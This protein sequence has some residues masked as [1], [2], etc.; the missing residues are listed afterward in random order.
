MSIPRPG[1]VLALGGLLA[2]AVARDA[3]GLV[4]T[5]VH[6]HAPGPQDE[7]RREEFVEIYNED[8]D[9]LDLSGYRFVEG[10]VYEFPARTFLQ[11]RSYLVI[12]AD[13]ARLRARHGITNAIGDWASSTSLDNGGESIALANPGGAVE[14][15][16]EYNDRGRW[17]AGADG[18]GLTLSLRD[19][20]ADPSRPES[21][22]ASAVA[23]GTPG[24]ANF[25]GGAP[26]PPTLVMNEA[27]IRTAGPRWVEIR[28]LRNATVN[29]S[30]HY[31]T[32]DPA[33][34]E[35]A[36][37]PA[38]SSIPPLGRI[39]FEDEPL[40]LDFSLDGPPVRDMVFVGLVDPAGRIV[41]AFSFRPTIDGASEARIPDGTGDMEPAA[42]PTPGAP[43]TVSVPT[44]IVINEI[45]YHPIDEDGS[46]EFIELWNRGGAEVDISGWSFTNGIT[47]TFP[48]TTRLAPGAFL[49]LARDPDRIRG[50]YGL[51]ASTVVGPLDAASLDAFGTLAD[52]GE[53]L[54]LV[55]ARGNTVDSVEYADG[56]E[57]P[58]WPDGGGSTLELIDA[59]QDNDTPQAWD[60]SDDSDKARS[61]R[62]EYTAKHNGGSA[63]ESEIHAML[64][65]KG[66]ALVDDL[67]I[68]GEAT[69]DVVQDEV[70]AKPGDT[71]LIH[72]GTAPPSSP[73]NAW[74]DPDFDASSWLQGTLPIGYGESNLGTTLDDMRFSYL[75]VCLRREFQVADPSIPDRLILEVDYDDGFIAYLNGGEVAR[76]N[77]PGSPPAHDAAAAESREAGTPQRIDITGRKSLLRSGKNVLALQLHNNIINSP[78]VFLTA[79]LYSGRNVSV[80]AGWNMVLNGSFEDP[81]DEEWLIKGTHARSGRTA[82]G[83]LQGSASLKLLAS[84][85]G[86]EKINHIERDIPK[87]LSV[88][89]E[90]RVS[91]EAKWV[92]GARSLLTCGHN[93][94]LARSHHLEVPENVGTPGAPNS[95][96]LRLLELSGA[97]N[98]GPVIDRV[99]T[100][101]AAPPPGQPVTL[102]ARIRD[103]DGVGSAVVRWALDSPLAAFSEIP[104]TGPDAEGFWSAEIPG[105]ALNTR[106]V[107][108]VAALDAGARPGRHPADI[109]RRTH[110]LLLDPANPSPVDLSWGIY[111]HIS[112]QATPHNPYHFWMHRPHEEYLSSRGVHS[113]EYLEGAFLFGSSTLYQGA[114]IRFQ[115]S[116][117][118]RAGWGGSFRIRFPSDRPLH[119]RSAR[120]N[121]DQDGPNARDRISHY[122]V[123]NNTGAIR[124]P[125]SNHSFARL[126]VNARAI[127]TRVRIDPPG[128]EYLSKWFPDDTDGELFEIDERY[129][130][131]DAGMA[132]TRRNAYWLHPP[133]P[134]EGSGE[135]PE[136]YR[137][138]FTLRADEDEDDFSNLIATARVLTPSLT[139]AAQFD[140]AIWSHLD[141]EEFVRVLTIRQ[142]T[143]DW[144]TWAGIFGRSAYIY[145]A[146]SDG[147]W[148]LFPWDSDKAYGVDSRS[149]ETQPLPATP[150]ETF[151]NP[152]PEVERLINRPA[153][154]RIYYAVLRQMVDG[155]FT[156][157]Y[158]APY[159]DLLEAAGASRESLAVGRVGGFIDLRGKLIRG[160]IGPHMYP[161]RRLSIATNGG[162]P[163]S[164]DSPA[165]TLTGTL[166]GGITTLAI[167]VNGVAA[168]EG[169]A[170]PSS[171]DFF[172]WSAAAIPLEPGLNDIEVLG[173]SPEGDLVDA[174]TI[175]V[176]RG[177]D[178]EVFL[179]G[180][181]D[182]DAVLS[183][184]DAV[185]ILSHL[186]QGGPMTCLD[187][188][189]VD[190]SGQLDITDPIRLLNYLFLGGSPPPPPFMS[191]GADP[192]PDGL[193]CRSGS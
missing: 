121:L 93:F 177:S 22:A 141:V 34:L 164:T 73:A 85:A 138:H 49:V 81:L 1:P 102:R 53:R 10:L 80:P 130:F 179:R 60:A 128:S 97:V 175:T 92:V 5:E 176:T 46:R 155:H 90:Y 166:P 12:C 178:A 181:T 172:G 152:F 98:L 101:P 184:T 120:F 147:L 110:P 35:K 192:T 153:V 66:I 137:F 13:A 28:N 159:L 86:D 125:F 119:G 87:G 108:E 132:L 148:R 139:P 99:V 27:L 189:D 142:N 193:D 109:T 57:W 116:A 43:N 59:A 45:H 68:D 52:G 124:V 42:D 64:L 63:S 23:G 83:A 135:D 136:S 160:W 186:F 174:A 16:V 187:A 106:V 111:G 84:G 40:G 65:S 36:A 123:R 29:L 169:T 18:T 94:G 77:L 182:L 37:L 161:Q 51:P 8:P 48:E 150:Q 33:L 168:P 17:P 14:A 76:G 143:G 75:G 162:L 7:A 55:D 154:K 3:R 54:K 58:E 117:L 140:E 9:P 26:A 188:A 78:D 126:S 62:F 70:Y 15:A 104:M 32:D 105:Q 56:G 50:I 157:E 134:G 167:V 107:Y 191:P 21:W 95:V 156:P 122:L 115:G 173:L 170:S 72:K 103:A 67:K 88:N 25:P 31:L 158:L 19:P 2:L 151:R 82:D 114:A 183:L 44:G 96:S 6:Y 113:D 133:Y 4:I 91:L 79:T 171:S 38:G 145:R 180:D 146:P 100:T 74:L 112:I 89:K 129:I 20:F 185:R 131:S 144:D 118:S 30:G 41:D 61:T 165:A 190:D 11:G 47:F 39:V 163:F 69:T 71:F 149:V 24:S 127:G